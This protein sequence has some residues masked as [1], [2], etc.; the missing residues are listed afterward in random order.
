M[1]F[2]GD[3]VNNTSIDLKPRTV[4]KNVQAVVFLND[5][6]TSASHVLELPHQHLYRKVEG[7]KGAIMTT[8]VD[9]R[10]GGPSSP[11]FYN[12][13]VAR[14]VSFATAESMYLTLSLGR[15]WGIVQEGS[16]R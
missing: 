9:Y 12:V 2:D 1:S 3:R 8:A 4:G 10:W 11:V 6:Y 15:R 13:W 14:T 7:K 16:R 5:V